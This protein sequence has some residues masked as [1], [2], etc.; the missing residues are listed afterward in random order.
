MQLLIEIKKDQSTI[1][2]LDGKKGWAT[3]KYYKRMFEGR[4]GVRPDMFMLHNI[5]MWFGGG[6]E[7]KWKTSR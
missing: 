2:D 6:L 7:A 5:Y 1:F 3:F 4:A